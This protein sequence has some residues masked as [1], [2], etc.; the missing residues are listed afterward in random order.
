MKLYEYLAKS[1]L[2]EVGIPTPQGR[3]ATTPEEAEAAARE[4][5]P[6]A[7]KAQVLVGGRGKA[8]GIKLANTP[9]EARQRAA[10]ILG[11]NLKGYIVEKVWVEQQLKIDRELYVSITVDGQAR[12]PLVIASAHG[13]VNIEEVPEEY[14]V[15]KNIDITTGLL[16]FHGREIARRLG[17]SGDLAKQFADILA[18]MYTAFR[19]YDAELVEINPLAVVGDRLIAADS[20]L[21]VEDDA[22]FRH[23]ELPRVEEGTELERK[24]RATGLAFVQLDGDIAVMA[25]GAGMAMG[26]LDVLS[27]YGGRPANF[28]D[29]GGGASVEPMAQ[30][31]RFLLETKPKAILINIFGGIT[32]CDDVARAIV[33][34]KETEGIPVPLVVRL[35]GTNDEEGRRI[36]AEAGI[37]AYTDMGEAAKAVVAAAYGEGR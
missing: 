19:K 31:I 24:V 7:V 28:L 27:L 20:R 21:N 26:T 22:L 33:T 36:L 6:C 2:A 16:P 35:V 9:E 30:A 14:I 1:L 10:E 15:K 17:L 8:G 25:N 29:A 37:H 18:K 5:G 34:V 11:M 3:L 4:I 12:Q 23:P 13:G 32:R